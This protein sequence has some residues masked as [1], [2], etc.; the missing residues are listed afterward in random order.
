MTLIQAAELLKVEFPDGMGEQALSKALCTVELIDA[1]QEKYDLFGP[2]HSCVRR[3]F[4]QVREQEA[5]SLWLDAACAYYMASD[6]AHRMAL[7]VP[8]TDGT[9]AR[10]FLA[11]FV[12]LPAVDG[13]YDRY[14][15]RGF[16]HERAVEFLGI[17]QMDISV[18]EA[19][20]LGRPA[21]D[22]GYYRWLTRFL[23]GGMFDEG[24]LKFELKEAAD[25]A[26]VLKNKKSGALVIL[27]NLEKAHQS[28]MPLGSAGFEEAEGSFSAAVK[29]TDAA[30][31]GH[32]I[33]NHRILREERVY[34]KAEWEVFLRAGEKIV[35]VHIPRKT[36]LTPEKIQAAYEG[37]RE[38]V[39]RCYPEY[40]VK[41]F[42]C[43][44]W[45]MDPA[46]NEMLGEQSRISQFSARY[47]RYPIISDGKGVFTFVFHPSDFEKLSQL[48]EQTTLQRKLKEKYLKGE[49]IYSYTGILPFDRV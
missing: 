14:R 5:L 7:S 1:L 33:E 37:A 49:Y 32:E 10:D 29:E 26:V 4:L 9:L 40:S 46:L 27:S 19:H 13:V 47:M 42:V 48:P 11:L 16:T 39:A 23:R 38:I 44:S 36:D 18:M 6:H 12:L 21:L 35:N 3:A 45:M 31:I 20:I 22:G 34:P 15:A 28:G 17:F 2:Y 30:Y 41:T 25:T 24:G 43:S 8:A